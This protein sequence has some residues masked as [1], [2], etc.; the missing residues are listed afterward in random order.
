MKQDKILVMGDLNPYTILSIT[1]EVNE[2]T[3]NDS[4]IYKF[5]FPKQHYLKKCKH[6]DRSALKNIA[7]HINKNIAKKLPC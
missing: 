1:E 4:L 3:I 6:L 7:C 2:P 5:E